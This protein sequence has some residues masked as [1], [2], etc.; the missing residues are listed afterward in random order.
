[1]KG[2]GLRPFGKNTVSLKESTNKRGAHTMMPP[3]IMFFLQQQR[4]RCC[5]TAACCTNEPLMPTRSRKG[6]S[7]LEPLRLYERNRER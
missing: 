6:A 5:E 7:F 1:M 4:R 2:R 3:D